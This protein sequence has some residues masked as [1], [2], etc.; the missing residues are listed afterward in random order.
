[1]A[2]DEAHCISQWGHDFRPSYKLIPNLYEIL[3]DDLQILA[4]TATA[5]KE[6]R[7]DIIRNLKLKDPFIKITGFD[8]S[9]IHI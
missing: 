7:E 2:V 4:F 3:G 6:V 8:L 5:T 1:M 9:L